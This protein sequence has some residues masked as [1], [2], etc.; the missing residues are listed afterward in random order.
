MKHLKPAFEFDQEAL[1]LLRKT[2]NQKVGLFFLGGAA[3][4]L[5]GV[6]V[7]RILGGEK[8]DW[9]MLGVGLG[10]SAISIP[11][12]SKY[13]KRIRRLAD[14]Y[15]TKALSSSK[16]SFQAQMELAASSNGIGLRISF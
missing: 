3:G 2:R 1:G 14:L 6:S 9:T 12:Y 4:S 15:N 16:Y 7:G 13:N 10:L 5:V 8:M 11:I